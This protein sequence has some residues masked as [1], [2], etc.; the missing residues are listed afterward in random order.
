MRSSC[1]FKGN[2]VSADSDISIYVLSSPML[3]SFVASDLARLAQ[4]LLVLLVF[5]TRHTC[6]S[7]RFFCAK[8]AFDL[9]STV[10][11]PA[12]RKIKGVSSAGASKIYIQKKVNPTSCISPPQDLNSSLQPPCSNA[13]VPG[14]TVR[15]CKAC[16]KGLYLPMPL[17]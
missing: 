17:S 15:R 5:R 2:P 10:L 16:V 4:C 9:K 12:R 1:L 13:H 7:I 3:M 6:S 8:S 14:K 11:V